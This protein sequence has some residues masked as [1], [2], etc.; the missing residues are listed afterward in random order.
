MKP[1]QA[2]VAVVPLLE[3]PL[4]LLAA[5]ELC[6]SALSI[7]LTDY[8]H[9]FFNV[10][11]LHVTINWEITQLCH[12]LVICVAFVLIGNLCLPETKKRTCLIHYHL[13]YYLLFSQGIYLGEILFFIVLCNLILDIVQS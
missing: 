11:V 2:Q 7:H 8:L 10:F 3:A 9:M 13:M 4:P 1:P 5:V 12:F 6:L